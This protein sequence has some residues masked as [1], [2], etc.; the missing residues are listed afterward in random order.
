MF[1]YLFLEDVEQFLNTTF[2]ESMFFGGR[3]TCFQVHLWRIYQYIIWCLFWSHRNP[4]GDTFWGLFTKC[5]SRYVDLNLR[6]LYSLWYKIYIYMYWV[7]SNNVAKPPTNRLVVSCS[8]LFPGVQWFWLRARR[9]GAF[10]KKKFGSTRLYSAHASSPRKCVL[11]D[12]LA[13]S[14]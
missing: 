4:G 2:S 13:P 12:M 6:T 10:Q 1:I 14:W 3:N 8:P 5:Y 7:F 9:G 11:T